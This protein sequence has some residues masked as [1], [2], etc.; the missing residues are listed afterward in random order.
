MNQEEQKNQLMEDIQSKFA[1]MKPE[2]ASQIILA[3]TLKLCRNIM[4]MTKLPVNPKVL[5]LL[6]NQKLIDQSEHQR[7]MDILDPK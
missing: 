1:E 2:M 5:D 4:D 7:L 6:L 3:E